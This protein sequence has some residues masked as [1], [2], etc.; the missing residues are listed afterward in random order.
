MILRCMEHCFART[1]PILMMLILSNIEFMKYPREPG[2]PGPIQP[3]HCVRRPGDGCHG[4]NG[5]QNTFCQ[6]ELST[7]TASLIFLLQT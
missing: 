3:R 7:W 2:W 4:L 6:C 5:D 1:P